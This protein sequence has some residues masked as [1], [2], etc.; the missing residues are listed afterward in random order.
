MLKRLRDLW[1]LPQRL[2]RLEAAHRQAAE[3][4]HR[5][6]RTATQ[7]KL[8]AL[9]DRGQQQEVEQLP[10]LFDTPRI[11]EHL[12]HAVASAP[13]LSDPFPHAIVERVLPDDVYDVLVRAIPPTVFFD[14]RKPVKQNLPL[15]M[16][17]APAFSARAWQYMDDVVAREMIRPAV[18]EKFHEPLEAHFASTFGPEFVAR[19]NALPQ[20]ASGGLLMLRRPGYYIGPHRDPKR[21]MITCLFYLAREGDNE[22]YGTQLFR[23]ANDGEAPY[24]QTY[25]PEAVGRN[26]E[27]VKTVPFRPN[28]MLVCLNS[29]GA[30]G[31][32]IPPDAPPT[33]ERYSYQ[34]YVAPDNEALSTLVKSLPQERRAMWRSKPDVMSEFA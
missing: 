22:A 23:V 3:Q 28:S 27:Y 7:M 10:A 34:F 19:A 2:E 29:R 30:H 33:V 9:L 21:A 6:D 25:Y 1:M 18:V 5:A 31:A 16:E 14:D 4:A 20:T 17:F 15:P 26:C 32:L 11:A 13:L 8:L 24:K 12:R